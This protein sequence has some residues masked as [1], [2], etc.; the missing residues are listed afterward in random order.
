M[1]A[2]IEQYFRS[3]QVSMQWSPVLFAL[4]RE[5]ESS[6]EKDQLRLMIKAVGIRFANSMLDQLSDLETLTDLND[7]LN[8]LWGR[9]QWGWVQFQEAADCIEIAH[10]FAP[11]AE[12]FGDQSL[13]WSVGLLEGF[14]ETVFNHFGSSASLKAKCISTGDQGQLIFIRCA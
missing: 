12:A 14:Y 2:S 6:A 4:A 10:Q 11:L 9:I 8:D 3:Q 1:T 5:L 13:D 7:A